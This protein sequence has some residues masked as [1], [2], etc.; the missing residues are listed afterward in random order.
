MEEHKMKTNEPIHIAS[1]DSVRI[2][3]WGLSWRWPFV[4]KWRALSPNEY[5]VDLMTGTFSFPNAIAGKEINFTYTTRK[6]NGERHV[7]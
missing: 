2:R 6:V 3:I 4:K 7:V 5:A 1:V